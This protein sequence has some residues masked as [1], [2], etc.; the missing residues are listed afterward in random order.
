MREIERGD[1]RDKRVSERSRGIEGIE[2]NERGN[3]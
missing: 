3:R 2:R 1:E